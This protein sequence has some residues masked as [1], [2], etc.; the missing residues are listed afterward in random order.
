MEVTAMRFDPDM[1]R[2]ISDTLAWQA[3]A[4]AV[5]AWLLALSALMLLTLAVSGVRARRRGDHN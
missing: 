4:V 1:Q 2:A 5:A 3:L